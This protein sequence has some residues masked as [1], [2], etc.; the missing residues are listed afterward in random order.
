[1]TANRSKHRK[2][3]LERGGKS[4]C[5]KTGAALQALT[6]ISIPSSIPFVML[7]PERREFYLKTVTC[8]HCIRRRYD[9]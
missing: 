6:V 4:A 3:H 1:M 2:T 7:K 5:G 8:M 9:L